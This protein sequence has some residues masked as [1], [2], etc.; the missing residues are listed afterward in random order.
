MTALAGVVDFTTT[1]TSL[2][3]RCAAAMAA[4]RRYGRREPALR[5]LAGACFGLSLT[6][7]LPEDEF[8]RQPLTNARH[9]LVADVRL[10]N[11]AEIIRALGESA[12]GFGER[13]DADLLMLALQ[14]W[15][16]TALDRITGSYAFAFYDVRERSLLLVRDPG[17]EKPLCYVSRGGHFRF[18][19]MPSGLFEENLPAFDLEAMAIRLAAPPIPAGRTSFEGIK[20]VLPGHKLKVTSG[21]LSQ[22]DFWQPSTE[23]GRGTD[24]EWVE[25][26]RHHLDN[27][28]SSCLR[29]SA[30]VIATQL[31]SGYDS[32]A[33]T[34][35]A[36]RELGR[37]KSLIA[38]TAVPTPGLPLIV[39]TNRIADESSW[40]SKTAAM[41]RIEHL[42]VNDEHPLLSS[43]DS[44]TFDLQEPVHNLFNMGWW[45]KVLGTARERQATA[46]LSA[47]MGNFTI[48][49]GGPVVLPFL[50]RSGRFSD[51]WREARAATAKNRNRWRGILMTTFESQLPQA[52][53]AAM[54]R[55]FLGAPGTDRFSFVRRHLTGPK[56]TPYRLP[57]GN[58][59]TAQ[60]AWFRRADA[61]MFN[62][63]M[64]AR[65]GVEQRDPS[66][67]RRLVEFC[68]SLP[69]DQLLRDGVYRPLARRALADRLPR[70]VLDLPVRGYQGADWYARLDPK[71]VD[72]A[73]E[74]IEASSTAT[75]L[76][77]V[78]R[79]R[80]A[81][82][83]WPSPTRESYEFMFAFGRALTNA[84]AA[85]KFIANAERNPSGFYR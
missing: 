36:G 85:G 79:M 1:A 72:E 65:T 4:Q 67:D 64:L 51:W 63:A 9:M 16:E 17:G 3:T 26:Y 12:S 50:M 41:H 71:S 57:G 84:V 42:V 45:L 8:D 13:A 34:A 35:T 77:D 48:S 74:E 66:A 56:S 78:G 5:S 31:S 40:A 25:R 23:I 29:T 21:Q 14:R 38:L 59:H 83:H 19:S 18:A 58:L 53:S 11:R 39:P 81:V 30:P 70:E 68:L 27:A 54:R 46:M 52:F 32:S 24:A 75:E 55:A 69:M 10:G 76:L 33:V 60:L 6:P 15:G 80:E 44:T 47:T 62:K 7:T 2:E 22:V 37:R 73:I 28:V 61:G 43:I 49:F 20:T 82:R